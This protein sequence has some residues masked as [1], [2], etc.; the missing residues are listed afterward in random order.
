MKGMTAMGMCRM[1]P[2]MEEAEAEAEAEMEAEAAEAEA[3]V[4]EAEAAR[5]IRPR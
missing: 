4:L 3:E 5:S 1:I 2:S